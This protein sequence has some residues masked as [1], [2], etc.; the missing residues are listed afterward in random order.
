MSNPMF[1]LKGPKIISN[2]HPA[3]FPL[4][5]AY[6]DLLFSINHAK[7][8]GLKKETI[9]ISETAAGLYNDAINN[10]LGDLDFAAVANI[11]KK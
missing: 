1:T 9:S 3:N 11:I 8:L 6:K 2:S 4:K 5:H 7:S 10:G